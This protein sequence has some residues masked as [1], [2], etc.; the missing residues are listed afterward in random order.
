ML[1]GCQSMPAKSSHSPSRVFR[2]LAFDIE[3]QRWTPAPGKPPLQ[4]DIIRHGPS[5]VILAL[6][7][8]QRLLLVRQY[9][10]AAGQFLW[11]L[12]AGTVEAD[13][14]PFA[15]ARRELAEETGYRARRWRRWARFFPSPGMLDEEM[16]AFLALDL[17]PGPARPEADEAIVTRWWPQERWQSA[18]RAGRIRD[19]KTLAALARWLIDPAGDGKSIA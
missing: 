7:A 2:G 12:P 15:C 1:P 5:A 13:E 3:R 4:R 8:R 10:A 17:L 19:G 18:L 9:R 11:E 16:H 6:D 14:T